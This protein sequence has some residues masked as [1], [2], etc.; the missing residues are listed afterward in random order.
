MELRKIRDRP[1]VIQKR[2]RADLTDQ[3]PDY[4]D[5][6]NMDVELEIDSHRNIEY[7]VAAEEGVHLPAGVETQEIAQ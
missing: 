4:I 3:P 1:P 5:Y 7:R 6:N 2:R